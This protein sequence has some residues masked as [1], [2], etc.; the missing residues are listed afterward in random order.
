MKPVLIFLLAFIFITTACDKKSSGGGTEVSPPANLNINAVISTDN[1]GNV[2]FTATATNAVVYLFDFGDGSNHV[3][4]NGVVTHKYTASATYTVTVVAKNSTN[5]SISKSITVAIQ[6]ERTLVWSDEFE[7]AGAPDAA[8][9]GYDLGA[10][11]WG[12]NEL[13]YYTNRPENV[14]VSGGTL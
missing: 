9:W 3:S 6:K 7:T 12:N 13:Q 11:G 8:K 5:Q 1:S 4:A 10:G 14:I 2:S